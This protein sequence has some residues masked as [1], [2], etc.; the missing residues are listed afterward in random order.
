MDRLID[1]VCDSAG[2]DDS[3]EVLMLKKRG[4]TAI[5]NAEEK[6]LPHSAALVA[7]LRRCIDAIGAGAQDR[8]RS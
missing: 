1:I 2:F 8:A 4:F 3:T 7:T 5:L 6:H